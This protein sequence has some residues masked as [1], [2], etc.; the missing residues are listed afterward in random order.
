MA[1]TSREEL[2]AYAEKFREE[3]ATKKKRVLVCAGTGCLANGSDKVI[4][5]FKRNSVDAVAIAKSGCHGFCEAGP[6]VRIEPDHI[7]Y[8]HV[9]PEDVEEIVE[10]TLKKGE[11]VERLLYHHPVT[12]EAY[13]GEGDIPFYKSQTRVALANCGAID[14]DD[15]REYIALGGF[16]G[17]C[18]GCGRSYA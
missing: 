5:E 9:K 15:I 14:P 18:Q 2:N 16:K 12:G 8:V 6:L 3:L 13:L 4:E 10:K 1:I 7:L 17:P 11:P